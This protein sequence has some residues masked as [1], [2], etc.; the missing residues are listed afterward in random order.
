MGSLKLL[1]VLYKDEQ[2][3]NKDLYSSGPYWNY[4]NTKAIYQIKK[5]GISDF[6]GLTTGI[7][8]SYADNIVLDTRNEL[9][10]KG[11]L[12]SKFFSLPFINTIFNSQIRLTKI[13]IESFLK[14][15]SIVYKKNENVKKLIEKYK[16][17][18]TTEF[19]CLRKFNYNG[20][21]YSTNYLNMAHRIEI[22]SKTFN[23]KKINSF[24]EIGGGFGSNIH[25]LI[26]NFPNIKKV[27]YLDA[28]PNIYIGTEYLKYFFGENVYDYLALQNKKKISF[29]NNNKL[30]ILCIPPW[31]IEN[32]EVKIDHF[33]NANSFVEMP[34]KVVENYSNF[35]KKF[36]TPEISLLSYDKYDPKTTFDPELLND[37]FDKKLSVEWKRDLIED[38]DRN[39]IYL[40]SR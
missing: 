2:L 21:D 3:C 35:V 34:K 29:S 7:A 11:R 16:F 20:K 28:V 23:F 32:L 14:N 26:T 17:N 38:Y 4:K 6:R 13:N 8:T 31:L 15:L 33:H 10:F 18:K 39:T 27:I 40:T 22:L 30:E 24:F 37:F 1:E 9:N 25:F 36:S 5:K 19:G 12:I